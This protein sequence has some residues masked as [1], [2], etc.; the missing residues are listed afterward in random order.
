MTVYGNFSADS[1]TNSGGTDVDGFSGLPGVVTAYSRGGQGYDEGSGGQSGYVTVTNYG[2]ITY[3]GTTSNTF[4]SLIQ[5]RSLGGSGATD[6]HNN[7]SN[8]GGGG[9]GQ[10]VSVTNRSAEHTSELQSLMRISYA[11]FCL[12]KKK[13]HTQ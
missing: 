13:K 5:A 6:N 9:L 3:N 7:D 10:A 8:G 1:T 11:V 2:N 4:N 12:K